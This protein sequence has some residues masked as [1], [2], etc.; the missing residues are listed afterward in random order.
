MTDATLTL[1]PKTP[2]LVLDQVGSNH[3]LGGY[4]LL[5]KL[6][7]LLCIFIALLHADPE[8]GESPQYQVHI[9]SHYSIGH[10]LDVEQYYNAIRVLISLWFQSLGITIIITI[11]TIITIIIT[12]I[13]TIIS[14]V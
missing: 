4:G 14:I 9:V 2:D 10:V 1:L 8:V 5:G 11:I 6:S 12:T 3:V 7:L 13:I